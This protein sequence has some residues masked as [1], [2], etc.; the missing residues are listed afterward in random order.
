MTEEPGCCYINP[1]QAYTKK[2]QDTCISFGTE[3]DCL[4]LTD[5]N[6]VPR[7]V[8]EPMNEYGDCSM[9]WPTTTETP[10]EPAGCC[11]GESY[12]ANDRCGKATTKSRCEDMGCSFLITDDPDDCVMTTT[13]TPTTTVVPGCCAHTSYMANEKCNSIEDKDQCNR[14]SSCNFIDWGILD[15]ECILEVWTEPPSEPGC[16]YGNPDAAYSKRWMDQCK[17]FGTEQECTMLLNGDGVPR[18]VF[19][20]LGEYEDCE[21][22]WPTTTE[23]PTEPAGCCKGS[24]YK[25][26]VKCLGLPDQKSCERKSCE[27]IVTMIPENC[28]VTT[29]ESP[30]TTVTPGCCK[31]TSRTSNDACNVIEDPDQCDRRSSCVF[32][33]F[34]ILDEDCQFPTDAPPSEPGCCYGNPD[35]AYSKR[36][37]ESCKTFATEEECLMLT[38]DDGEP[39]CYFEPLGEYEDCET[40]WPTTTTTTEEIGCCYADSYKANDKCGRATDRARCESMGCSFL[41][42]D[43][44]DDCL[45]T[46]TSSPT[47]TEELGCCYGEGVKENEMCGN[48]VGRDQCERSGKCEFREGA[49]ADCEF[50]PTTTTS[51]PWLGAKDEAVPFG[52]QGAVLSEAMNTQVSLSTILLLAVVALAAQQL[53]KWWSASRASAGY[54]KLAEGSGAPRS[55]VHTTYQSA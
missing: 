2:Y 18:C 12:K 15:I 37:M 28:D 48:K 51:E 52:E 44:P 47:T 14:R 33:A 42:T 6:G 17:T 27:W 53:Y 5:S 9:L 1:D 50:V 46:T 11:Y 26:Q 38:N 16:C 45:M 10:T 41:V 23:T 7:C 40:V 25:A 30:T 43:D 54:T 21:T 4:K 55:G 19:E 34:G 36:W 39:R 29:T 20:P 49:D 32:I 22:V 24:S 3:R 35:I 31:G 13:E 8:F